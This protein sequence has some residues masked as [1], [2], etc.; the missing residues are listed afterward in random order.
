MGFLLDTSA[1]VAFERANRSLKDRCAQKGISEI[2]IPAI[3]VAELWISVE[4][5]PEGEK[6]AARLQKIQSFVSSL[7]VLS[8][9]EEIAPTYARLYAT[10]RHQGMPIPQNDLSIA[11]T[12]VHFNHTLVIGPADEKHFRQVP[13]LSLEVVDPSSGAPPAS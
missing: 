1:V 11:A 6:R 12:A 3:V 4:L 2:F 13:G 7:Q 5:T 9:T 10:L 8:F